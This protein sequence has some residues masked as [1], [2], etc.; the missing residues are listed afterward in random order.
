M[1]SPE[2]VYMRKRKAE[3]ILTD[4]FLQTL[5]KIVKNLLKLR[6]AIALIDW[7]IR[8]HKCE[9]FYWTQVDKISYLMSSAVPQTACGLEVW[10]R[11]CLVQRRD[12][13]VLVLLG[14][15]SVVTLDQ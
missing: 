11:S 15:S 5:C 2:V 12:E 4:F 7:T 14:D 3:S 10:V 8:I 13:Y 9:C 1:P 6:T